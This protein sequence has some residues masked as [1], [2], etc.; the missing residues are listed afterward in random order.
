MFAVVLAA[1][2]AGAVVIALVLASDHIENKA[3]SAV[4]QPVVAWSFIGT[5]LYA[6]RRRPESRT[7][8]LMVAMGFAWFLAS[9]DVANSPF[10]Y[11]TGLVTGGL[12]GA[13]FLHLGMSF[14][15]GRL[16]EP[17]DRGLVAAGYVIFPLAFVPS[18]LFSGPHEL[19][20]DHCPT[21]L[22]LIERD[23]TLAAVLRGV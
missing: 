8:A 23:E 5:G 12:F 15:T 18:V 7:G 20:C 21:N 16:Q 3:V 19:A 10:V 1:L 14:P 22:L 6:W 9:L 11:T 2:A 17:F 4:L 13:L